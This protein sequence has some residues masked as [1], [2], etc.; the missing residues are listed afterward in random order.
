M[1]YLSRS[2]VA[3]GRQCDRSIRYPTAAMT[4]K[5]MH[6]GVS[7]TPWFR[8]PLFSINP[9]YHNCLI[10]VCLTRI[11]H[12]NR[13]S[14]EA[15][16]P[17]WR[18]RRGPVWLAGVRPGGRINLCSLPKCPG[19][20]V[21][22]RVGRRVLRAASLLRVLAAW[23]FTAG[24]AREPSLSGRIGAMRMSFSALICAVMSIIACELMYR[25][26]SICFI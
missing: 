4:V 7:V 18:S 5:R 10:Y 12:I 23:A 8:T 16:G 15:G 6:L 2:P 20:E 22:V 13:N 17:Q 11:E 26:P 19:P 21:D 24:P 3:P 25:P 14:I 1:L 9:L